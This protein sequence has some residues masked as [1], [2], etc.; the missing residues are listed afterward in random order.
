MVTTL[1]ISGPKGG[2]GKSMIAVNLAA[3]LALYEKKVLLIDCDPG[4]CATEW[5]GINDSRH[6]YDISS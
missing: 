2:I 5:I 3:T 1:T 4:G 6:R